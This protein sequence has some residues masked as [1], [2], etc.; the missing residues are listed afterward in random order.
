[1]SA[2]EAAVDARLAAALERPQELL[3][4]VSVLRP[5][6]AANRPGSLLDST[7]A[8]VADEPRRIA[9]SRGAQIADRAAL[10]RALTAA[11]R[12]RGVDP[13]VMLQIHVAIA[14]RL[15]PV[16]MGPAALAALAAYARAACFDRALV[17]H[18]PP[19]ALQ[20]RDLDAGHEGGLSAAVTAAKDI[21][22]ISIAILEGVNRA[23]LEAT[24]VPA[25]Q[26]RDLGLSPMSAVPGL[27]LAATLVAGA[28]TVPITPML[29]THA[30]ALYATGEP[31]ADPQ[32]AASG[33]D[34]SLASELLQLGDPP[35]A[36]IDELLHSW[37]DCLELRPTLLRLGASLA[38]VID[39]EKVIVDALLHGVVL[40]FI[41]TLMSE[42]DRAEAV[43]AVGDADGALSGALRRLRR[44]LC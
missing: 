43:A 20:P 28:T 7:S 2:A 26:L 31:V 38:R 41:A 33:N 34:L 24:L 16:T 6:L 4:Q 1:M 25:L 15:M 17:V 10:R 42:E 5:L 8:P 27:R 22:G 14:A 19:T 39:D 11:A 18:V 3:A 30:V 37:P 44:R 35:V 40:P 29:W 9:W 23:P 13:S 21:D 32:A 36:A 12:A